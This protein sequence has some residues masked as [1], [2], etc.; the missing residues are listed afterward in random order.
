M[1]NVVGTESTPYFTASLTLSPTL[2]QG[3]G[4]RGVIKH[5]TVQD[6]FHVEDLRHC[7]GLLTL[8]FGQ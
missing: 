8:V 7:I 1:R 5:F 2:Y 4:L 3:V 6:R